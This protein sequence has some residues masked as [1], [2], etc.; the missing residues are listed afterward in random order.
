MTRDD[1]INAAFR[2][3]GR[4]FYKTT[5]L[6]KIAETLNVSKPALYRHFSSKEALLEA[7]E[8]RFYDDYADVIKPIIVETLKNNNWQ[9]RLLAM[10]RFITSYFAR[11]F[12]YFIFS[13]IKL[14]EKKLFFSEALK[15]RG[16]S[17]TE[18][19]RQVVPD[20]QYPSALFLAGVTSLFGTALFHKQH[21]KIFRDGSA[22]LVDGEFTEEPSE[23]ELR[24]FTGVTVQRVW[25]GLGFNRA[26]ID[27]LPYTKLE[28]L[29]AEKNLR[30]QTAGD[31]LLQ[32]VA[33]AVAEAGPWDASME[34]V[35]KRSGL[36]KS[37]LYAHFKSKQDMLSRLFMTE[38]ER[39]AEN[40]AAQIPLGETR[41]EQL[42]LAILSIAGYLQSRTEILIA[43]D[44][45]RIQRLE[46][47]LS[48]PPTLIDFFAGLNLTSSGTSS[49]SPEEKRENI[50][51]WI[52]F[53]LV[54]VL[55]RR[56]YQEDT[57]TGRI[58]NDSLRKIFRFVTLGVEGLE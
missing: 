35:A 33:G 55:M 49:D 19:G 21:R 25:Q 56:L 47:D 2:V 17:F 30:T 52:L 34:T 43:L 14:H 23:E 37:G 46:L 50:S 40:T 28:N 51:Q 41:E 9:E 29:S 6:A 26:V 44:W 54:T 38:F 16:V 39:I 10:V 3:W 24:Y 22:L 5:S 48:V 45:V 57:E 13:L 58:N 12:E 20:Q 18:L 11:H 53:L 7:M 8:N 15:K 36:S 27:A 1:V 4:E 32:A 31:P 42:Y